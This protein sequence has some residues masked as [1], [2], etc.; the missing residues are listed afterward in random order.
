LRRER[1]TLGH[2]LF[3]AEQQN[4]EHDKSASGV[5]S[6]QDNPRAITSESNDFW[7]GETA[8][9]RADFLVELRGFEPVAIARPRGDVRLHPRSDAQHSKRRDVASSPAA[10]T[11]FACGEMGRSGSSTSAAVSALSSRVKAT[12]IVSTSFLSKRLRNRS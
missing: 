6:P 11:K 3:G 9:A 10:V 12:L 2:V 8:T 5:P 4:R 1:N 7:D